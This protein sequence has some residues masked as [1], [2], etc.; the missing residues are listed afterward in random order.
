MINYSCLFII[1]IISW[2]VGIAVYI[3]Q[4]KVNEAKQRE[5]FLVL[6]HEFKK[7]DTK[8]ILAED[9]TKTQ[10]ELTKEFKKLQNSMTG[11]LADNDLDKAI[12]L[13]DKYSEIVDAIAKKKEHTLSSDL[14]TDNLTIKKLLELH[15]S[16]FPENYE[17]AGKIRKVS[18]CIESEKSKEPRLV[19]P[20][21][22]K[23]RH[24]LKNILLWWGEKSKQLQNSTKE[25][26]IDAIAQFHHQFLVIHPFLDGNGRIARLL[27]K[28]QLKEQF[29]KNVELEFSK[30]EY[31]EALSRADKEDRT[32]LKELIANL[33]EKNQRHST[34]D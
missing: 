9:I 22:D 30:K 2:I 16:L 14:Q 19:P 27:L 29:Q 33:L 3:S 31:Y 21:A 23:V 32:K 12:S 5:N 26:K 24:L 34:F 13:A 4:K 28:L 8:N 7:S 11:F 1:L 18:V 6:Y 15:C 20:P 25:D 17:L 10:E